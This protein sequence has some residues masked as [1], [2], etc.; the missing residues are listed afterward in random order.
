V[1]EDFVALDHGRVLVLCRY[2]GTG[3]ASG[4]AVEQSAAVLFEMRDGL[5]V[6][7]QNFWHRDQGREAAGLPDDVPRSDQEIVRAIY[8]RWNRNDGSLAL[9]FFDP[10]VDVHQNPDILDTARTFRG[11]EGLAA[12]G[13]ELVHAFRRID[14]NLK[15]WSRVGAWLLAEVHVHGVGRSSGLGVAVDVI[16]AW[17]LR[18]GKVTHFYVYPGLERAR[19]ELPRQ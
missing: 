12:S 15:G 5:I 2:L 3:Q 11:H 16:H 13:R 7:M 6:Y 10:D 19:A 14:W 8:E 17:R 4:L 9:E 1:P 18:A